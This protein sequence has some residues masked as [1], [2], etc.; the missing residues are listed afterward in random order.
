M[1]HMC[2]VLFVIRSRYLAHLVLIC[3]HKEKQEA[4]VSAVFEFCRLSFEFLALALP[5]V[6]PSTCKLGVLGTNQI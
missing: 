3:R 1:I 2:F 6:L 4:L 5:S